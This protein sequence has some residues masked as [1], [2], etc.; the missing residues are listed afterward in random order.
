MSE[1]KELHSKLSMSARPRWAI[2]P[3]SVP[4]SEGMP[5]ESGP[6]AEEGT[7]AHKVAEFYVR[8]RF[9]LEGAQVGIPPEYKPPEGLD[10]K[11][12]TV[13]G[14]NAKLRL[15]GQDYAE[16]IAKLAGNYPDVRIVLERRVEVQGIEPPLFGTADCLLWFPSIRRLAVVDY[17]YGFAEVDV[18]DASDPN[19]QVAAYAVA[20]AETFG[21]DVAEVGLAIYQPRRIHGEAGQVLLLPNGWLATEHAKLMREAKA[22]EAAYAARGGVPVPGAHCRY[23]P[24][25]S[26]CTATH[27]AAKAALQSHVKASM[28][29][30]MTDAEIISLWAIRTAFKNFWEDIEERI[31]KMAEAGA[32]GLVVKVATGRK[33]WADPDAAVLTLLALGRVDLLAPGSLG[34]ALPAIPAELQDALVKRANGAKTILATAAADPQTVAAVFDRYAMKATS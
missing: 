4:W 17:K 19:E 20:A 14:W 34:D 29:H 23:C 6:A 21:L 8:Q 26:R 7:T 30:D 18:G 16:F 31:G 32:A 25:A 10:L 1:G 15:H 33:M 22:V 24:A 2:C 5:N 11:G 28:V 27:T 12:Q 3:V 13:N 9:N